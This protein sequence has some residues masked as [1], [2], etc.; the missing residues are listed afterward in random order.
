ML[1]VASMG[2]NMEA[3]RR[4]SHSRRESSGPAPDLAALRAAPIPRAW[5]ARDALVV[6]RALVGC[7]VVHES[8][9]EGGAASAPTARIARIVETEAYRGPTDLA[10]HARAGL[11]RRTRTL[12]GPEGHAYVFLVYGMHDCFNVTCA[13]E[14]R[15]HAV[16][17]RA[18]EPMSG[19]DEDARLDGPGRFARAMGIT[20]ALDGIAL[21]EPPLY[22]CP[23]R[24]RPR[25]AV[26]PRVGVAYAGEWADRPWRFYDVATAHVSRPPRSAVG[27]G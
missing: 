22:L 2:G 13:A 7:F 4:V 18:G 14:G 11:T 15:G 6:A 26:T 25:I 9:G 5:Y 1:G 8:A 19:F 24:G 16:L 12:L 20:R 3:P 21:T 23:R 10:C 17:V 27:R